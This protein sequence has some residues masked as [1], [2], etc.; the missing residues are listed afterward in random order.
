M[1][2]SK[3]TVGE[4]AA[5][6]VFGAKDYSEHA[7]GVEQCYSIDPAERAGSLRRSLAKMA[8]RDSHQLG[9]ELSSASVPSSTPP[10]G[11]PPRT[12]CSGTSNPFPA[13]P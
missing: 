6:L 1:S 13:A 8:E 3:W 10:E 12:C 4:A 5:H 11:G 2:G 7:R 9:V